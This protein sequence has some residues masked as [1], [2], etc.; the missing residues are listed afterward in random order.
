MP[1]NIRELM[2][3]FDRVGVKCKRKSSKLNG[4]VIIGMDS[5]KVYSSGG[6]PS[7]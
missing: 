4:V 2:D 3:F 1:T 7:A 6:N 5:E